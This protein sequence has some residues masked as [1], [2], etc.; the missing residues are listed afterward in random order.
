MP[1][2]APSTLANVR[3]IVAVHSAKGGVGKSTVATNLAAALARMGLSVGVLDADVHGPSIAHMFGSSEPPEA[4]P[5]TDLAKPLFRH[6][7]HYLSIAN[8]AVEGA[9]IVWRGPMVSQ[10]IAQLLAVGD[11][12]DLDILLID[13]PPGTGDAVLGL[14]QSVRFSGAVTVTTPQEMSLSDTRRGIRAFEALQVPMLGIVENM[15]GFVCDGCGDHV[16]L[17]GEGGGE[18]AAV[19]MGL[20]FLGRIPMEPAV[21]AGGDAGTPVCV[22]H[23]EAASARAFTAVARSVLGRLAEAGHSGAFDITWRRMNPKDFEKNP[24]KGAPHGGKSA[25]NLPLAVWQAADDALGILW[26]DGEKTYHGSFALRQACPCA[27]CVEEWTGK[28][29]E[30]LDAVPADVRPVTIHSVGR[31]ALQ[32]VWSDGHRT[33]LYSFEELRSGVG[34]VKKR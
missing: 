9:P 15:A 20:P 16:A 7:V 19:Q 22:T 2:A 14:G 24:P 8:M 1:P 27:G 29:M 25:A 17:F 32:P 4:S 11:W 26:G 23:P 21:M 31:Y 30:S 12:G 28:R 3:D 5:G 33:G 6:G 13:M 10:A 18:A 34:A